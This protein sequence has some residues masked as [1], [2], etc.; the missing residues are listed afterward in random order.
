M[1]A[2]VVVGRVAVDLP[3]D[4]NGTVPEDG[5]RPTADDRERQLSVSP[6]CSELGSMRSVAL[7]K[8]RDVVM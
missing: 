7:D 1:I 6:K 2:N 8:A 5:S 3:P 4:T